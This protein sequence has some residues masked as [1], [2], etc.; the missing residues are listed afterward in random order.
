MP[1]SIE[2]A[3]A[4][5]FCVRVQWSGC[6]AATLVRYISLATGAQHVATRSDVQLSPSLRVVSCSAELQLR[7]VSIRIGTRRRQPRMTACLASEWILVTDR[8]GG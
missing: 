3:D 4:T 5:S 7:S 8:S 2:I 6:L 1:Q